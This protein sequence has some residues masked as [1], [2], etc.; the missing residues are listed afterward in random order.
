M[1]LLTAVGIEAQPTPLPL[2]QDAPSAY[3]HLN[4]PL[5]N[6]LD[7]QHEENRLLA[8]P[9]LYCILGTAATDSTEVGILVKNI[10]AAHYKYYK[11]EQESNGYVCA[12]AHDTW[13]FVWA[14]LNARWAHFTN[15]TT[16]PKYR[17]LSQILGLPDTDVRDTI[18]ILKVK[19]ADLFRPAYQTNI[20]TKVT[21][22]PHNRYAIP[23]SPGTPIGT[24]FLDQIST[25]TMPWTRMGYTYNW[26]TTD[27]NDYFGLAEFIFPKGKHARYVGYRLVN[28]LP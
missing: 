20:T 25:N 15:L 16:L 27:A 26:G 18:V 24:F 13:V 9:N 6:R 28:S 11:K 8:C 23:P 12:P 1:L 4:H 2:F 21:Q 10:G 22:D 5:I 7:P 17:R 3:Y 19:N 14:D